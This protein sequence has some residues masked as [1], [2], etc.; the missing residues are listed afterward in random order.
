MTAT[1]TIPPWPER[2]PLLRLRVSATTYDEAEELLI[3]AARER[4]RTLVDHLSVHGLV[5]ANRDAEFAEAIDAFDIVA[6]DGQPVRWALNTLRGTQLADRV[7]GPELMKRLCRRAAR[8]GIS[9][10]LYGSSGDVLERLSEALLEQFPSLVIA[11]AEAPP[12]RELSVEEQREAVA[13]MN[14]S[15]AGLIFI[16]L[17]CP[18]QELFAF[19]NRDRMEGVQLCVGAAFDF[20]SGQKKTAPRWMQERG[21]EW[22]FRLGCEPRRLVGRY[23]VHN[24]L[25]VLHMAREFGRLRTGSRRS[26]EGMNGTGTGVM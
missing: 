7:Y 2:H 12:F 19:H 4:R 5:H 24:S 25:F 22:L 8:E 1:A 18:K 26:R 10:Y 16:G 13:R 14:E 11:G 3:G 9:I 6:P 20:L 21:L 15:G 23:L 17:G